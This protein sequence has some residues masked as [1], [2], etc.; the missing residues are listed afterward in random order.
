ML[1]GLFFSTII[2]TF[3]FSACNNAEQGAQD[4][5]ESEM[6]KTYA[7]EEPFKPQHVDLPDTPPSQAQ[8]Q[9]SFNLDVDAFT[10]YS[11][12]ESEGSFEEPPL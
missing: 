1:K 8:E 6:L 11:S 5:S 2:L 7:K 10:T 3:L 12:E 9:T 4:E